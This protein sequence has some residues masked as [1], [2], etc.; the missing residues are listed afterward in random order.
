[1]FTISESPGAKSSRS[2]KT[3]RT[4]W[5]LHTSWKVSFCLPI[6]KGRFSATKCLVAFIFMFS[7]NTNRCQQPSTLNLKIKLIHA[8]FVITMM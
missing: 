3:A 2:L 5:E 6:A 1:M 7:V 4:Q 8:L